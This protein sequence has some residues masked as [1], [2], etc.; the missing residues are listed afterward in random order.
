MPELSGRQFSYRS[1]PSVPSFDDSRA[2]FVFDGVCVLCSGGASLVMR[3]DQDERVNFTPAQS[4]L[5]IALYR[6]FGV[7]WNETYLLVDQGRAYT[8]SAGYL[9]LVSILGGAWR[10]LRV[11]SVIPEVLRDAAYKVVA[12]NRYRWFGT[13]NQCALLTRE[14]RARLL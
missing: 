5:G 4:E 11:G 2:L 3:H 1:D 6:H 14:Q 10:F 7:D 8:A 13:A 12:R 9:H